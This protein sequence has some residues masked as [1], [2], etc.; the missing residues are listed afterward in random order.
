MTRYIIYEEG[1][2]EIA[3]VDKE[4]LKELMQ[5]GLIKI[6]DRIEEIETEDD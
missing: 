4:E 5:E 3:N 1:N 2:C 6:T